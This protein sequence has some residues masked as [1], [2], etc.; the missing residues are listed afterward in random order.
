ME[1]SGDDSPMIPSKLRSSRRESKEFGRYDT[2]KN[3][4]KNAKKSKN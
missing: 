2:R 1:V 3:V 4:I